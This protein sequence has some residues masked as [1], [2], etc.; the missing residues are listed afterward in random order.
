MNM[1]MF[2]AVPDKSK[3]SKWDF[4]IIFKIEPLK[5]LN[6]LHEVLEALYKLS[7]LDG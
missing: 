3:Q 2:S 5:R 4:L 6:I 7:V 1:F